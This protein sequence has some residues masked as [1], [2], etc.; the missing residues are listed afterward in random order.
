MNGWGHTGFEIDANGI[1]VAEFVATAEE[2]QVKIAT[3]DWSSEYANG[4]DITVDGDELTNISGKSGNMH[5]KGCVVGKTYQVICKPNYG[6][7]D[8]KVVTK[9]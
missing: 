6:A 5:I 9:E 2:L 7:V 1:G 3:N 4:K 8:V